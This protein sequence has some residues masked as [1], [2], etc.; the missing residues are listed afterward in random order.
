MGSI[1][2]WCLCACLGFFAL[3]GLIEWFDSLRFPGDRDHVACKISDKL[4]STMIILSA[5]SASCFIAVVV[6]GVAAWLSGYVSF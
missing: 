5:V 3:A 2:V 6:A 1:A 4:I